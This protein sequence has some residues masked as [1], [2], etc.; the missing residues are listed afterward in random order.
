MGEFKK[1]Y[2]NTKEVIFKINE[3]IDIYAKIEKLTDLLTEDRFLVQCSDM[4]AKVQFKIYRLNVVQYCATS[5]D[6]HMRDY[7]NTM[8]SFASSKEL[9]TLLLAKYFSDYLT[10]TNIISIL[11]WEIPRKITKND[12]EILNK[13]Y[14]KYNIKF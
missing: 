7:Y 13:L 12:F 2:D 10:I 1:T 5:K 14:G 6:I 3:L 11:V 4:P 9:E 8:S